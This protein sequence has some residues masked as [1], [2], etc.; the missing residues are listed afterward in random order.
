MVQSL[1]FCN[2]NGKFNFTLY[3]ASTD[4]PVLVFKLFHIKKVLWRCDHLFH[5]IFILVFSLHVSLSRHIATWHLDNIAI[6]KGRYSLTDDFHGNYY[7]SL[8]ILAA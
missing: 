1:V 6:L 2:G 7:I 3:L 8:D 4:L 5:K